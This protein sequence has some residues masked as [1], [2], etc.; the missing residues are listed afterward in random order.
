[1]PDKV[2]NPPHY[3]QHPSGIECIDVTEH[4]N[5]NLGNAVK[6]IWRAGL[7]DEAI[8]DL[9]K[10]IWYINREIKR[11]RVAPRQ[12]VA[13]ES[14]LPEHPTAVGTGRDLPV[15][16]GL[17][18]DESQTEGLVD[19]KVQQTVQSE[20]SPVLVDRHESEDNIISG[21]KEPD[22]VR[23]PSTLPVNDTDIFLYA[24]GVSSGIR[25]TG[26]KREQDG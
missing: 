9:R 25:F 24:S 11:L 13:A 18:S 26:V 2:N 17:D 21:N 3:T 16:E 1:M 10:A 4:M 8:D 7:K 5:F 14:T 20:N 23:V 15:R 12:A 19:T 6:Y 22:T